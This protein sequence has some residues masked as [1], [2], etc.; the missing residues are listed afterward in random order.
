MPF[1]ERSRNFVFAAMVAGLLFAAPAGGA[2]TVTTFT[3]VNIVRPELNDVETD[4]TIVVTG[5][6]ISRTGPSET[7][8]APPGSEIVDAAGTYVMPGLVEMHAHV[9]HHQRGEAYLND[10][11]FLWVANG[12]TTIRGM[13]GEPEHLE[14]RGRIE[15][16]ETLGPRLVTAGPPIIGGKVK[17]PA[18]AAAMVIAQKEAGYDFIKVHMGITRP[19]YD[20]ASRTANEKGIPFAGHVAEDV[21]LGRVL[22]V[23]QATIDHLDGYVPALVRADADTGNVDYGL[24]GAPL[25]PF[26]DPERMI[27]VARETAEAGVWNVPTLSMA[28]RFI[29]PVELSAS[30]PGLVY[31]PPRMVKGWITAAK[32]FQATAVADPAAARQF[33]IYRKQLVKSLHDV[34]AGLL[35]G[36]DAPQI[37]NVPGFS[38]HDELRLLIEAGLT[39]AEAR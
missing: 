25:T 22:E 32:G 23:R 29:G 39:P 26:V 9:P 15:S 14:L 36:S 24:L 16:G 37:L 30:A 4:Q 12:V 18:Q 17:T 28:E 13:N 35:L 20:A 5:T 3:H 27:V 33:L 21:G 38:I 19:V 31:M 10:V 7:L 6:R 1:P 2:P 11:L 8:S 34:D